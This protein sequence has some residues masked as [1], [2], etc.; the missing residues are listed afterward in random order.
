LHAD[1]HRGNK[2][3]AGQKP[4]SAYCYNDWQMALFWDLLFL[5]V[6][7]A[8]HGTV[9]AQVLRPLLTDVVGCQDRPTLMAFGAK[10]R[11]GR[12]SISPRDFCRFG[13]LYMRQ[14]RWNDVQVL[15]EDYAVMATSSPLPAGLPR[16]GG[17]IAEMS[18]GQRTLGSAQKPDNQCPHLGSYSF[19][20]RVIPHVHAVVGYP[21]IRPL[22]FS[23]SRPPPG[24][25]RWPPMATRTAGAKDRPRAS[26]RVAH[27]ADG[28]VFS[29]ATNKQP[30]ADSFACPAENTPC[31]KCLCICTDISY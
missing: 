3:I 19:L 29:R 12:V 17:Q 24:R 6:Y 7:G 11:P 18:P 2:P 1:Y 30:V 27:G 23:A 20:W 4:G 14:G 26:A 15:K 22:L 21:P 8:E 5:K 10:D 31:P 13:L 9:D 28:A 25:P 16:A